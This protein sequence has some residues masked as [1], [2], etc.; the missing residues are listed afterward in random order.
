[1]TELRKEIKGKENHHTKVKLQSPQPRIDTNK[2]LLRNTE[3]G[4][5]KTQKNENEEEIKWVRSKVVELEENKCA[6]FEILNIK[7]IQLNRT[8]I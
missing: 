1:M 7:I 4:Q 8:Y 3:E 6:Q 2:M 5:E